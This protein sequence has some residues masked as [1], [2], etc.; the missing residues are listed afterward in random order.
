MPPLNS[1]TRTCLA[2]AIGQALLSPVQAATIEVNADIDTSGNDALCTLREAIVSANEGSVLPND[3]C[4]DGDGADTIVFASFLA[5]R[6]IDLTQGTPLTI[7][8][9]IHIQGPSGVQLIIDGG[10]NSSVFAIY[11]AT[12]SINDLTISGG[13][14]PTPGGGLKIRSQNNIPSVVNLTRVTLDGN[15]TADS[16]GGAFSLDSTLVITDSAVSNNVSSNASRGGGAVSITA[17]VTSASLILNNTSVTDNTAS[18]YGGAIQ[19]SGALVNIV[20]STVS[21]NT[22]VSNG[23]GAIRLKTSSILTVLDSDLLD[24]VAS[25]GGGGGILS[26]SSMVTI[27]KSTV[28]GNTALDDGTGGGLNFAGTGSFTVTNSTIAGN[29]ATGSGGGLALFLSSPA[30]IINSTVSGNSSDIGGGGIWSLVQTIDILNSTLTGNIISGANGDGGGILALSGSSVTLRN[31]IVAGNLGAGSGV[32]EIANSGANVY[33]AYFNLLGDSRH[34]NAAAFSGGFLPSGT[35]INGSLDD[36]ESLSLASIISPLAVNGGATETHAL[37]IG[38]R[39]IGSGSGAICIGLNISS[40]DQRGAPRSADCDIGSFELSQSATITVNTKDDSSGTGECSLRDAILSGNSASSYGGCA[41]GSDI[42]NIVFDTGVFANSKTNLITL[43][44]SLPKVY[45]KTLINENGETGIT[46]DAAGT[47][48][49]LEVAGE[50]SLD[51]LTLTGGSTTSGCAGIYAASS[52][53]LTINNSTIAGNSATS[54]GGGICFNGIG[55]LLNSAVS[56][57]AA[58]AAGGVRGKGVDSK[59]QL[60]HSTVT[61]NSAITGTGG[62]VVS[63]SGA[64][65]S[66]VNSIVAGNNAFELGAE[67]Y[68]NGGVFTSLGFNVLGDDRYSNASDEAFFGFPPPELS[69]DDITATIDGSHPT[70]LTAIIKPLASNGGPTKTHGLVKDSPALDAGDN[71]ICGDMNQVITDQRG[72]LREDGACDIGSVEGLVDDGSFMVIPLA[73]G[74]V[75]VIPQ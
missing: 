8:S 4:V 6:A 31:S 15:T 50:V 12:T 32:H 66:L 60:I 49:V 73:S 1:L 17:G 33:A 21:G 67:L 64:T 14:S 38:S 70:E 20:N 10:G 11:G 42:N 63:D 72:E 65:V 22:S 44:S 13:S 45:N 43:A 26:D 5:G 40:K 18:G 53:D 58:R 3:G 52:S 48:R 16:G 59:V 37:P 2:L 27:D 71:S 69:G 28:S 39:A 35:D 47:G 54:D 57:N 23:G 68:N 34:D 61:N 25:T 7:T 19:A 24:N 74:K 41:A 55:K 36:G 9:D 75:V 56:G 29:V 62:G 30:K 46:V 51:K